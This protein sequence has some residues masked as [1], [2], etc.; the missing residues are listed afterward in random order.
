M[1]ANPFLAV[2]FPQ[3]TTSFGAD[4]VTVRATTTVASPDQ[5]L[6]LYILFS[7]GGGLIAN[8]ELATQMANWGFAV[9]KFVPNEAG[10]RY[11]RSMSIDPPREL[12][13]ITCDG[14]A[15]KDAGGNP[16]CRA[17]EG[18]KRIGESEAQSLGLLTKADYDAAFKFVSPKAVAGYRYFVGTRQPTPDEE[19]AALFVA[20]RWDAIAE[21]VSKMQ[22]T[23]AL[24][25]R[26]FSPK[27]T[28]KIGDLLVWLAETAQPVMVFKQEHPESFPGQ[29][30]QI[31]MGVLP[32]LPAITAGMIYAGIALIGLC[33]VGGVAVYLAQKT[34]EANR[35]Y[36]EAN[37]AYQEIE[38]ELADCIRDPNNS[39]MQR[40]FCKTALNEILGHKPQ[41]PKTQM[42][43][44][45]DLLKVALPL[46]GIGAAAIYVGPAILSASRTAASGI[47]T[48]RQRRITAQD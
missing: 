8:E 14:F 9:M 42:E 31:S 23:M 33:V 21:M 38:E 41:P 43:Q 32:A 12:G 25:G 40:Q 15:T 36:A 16:S 19:G 2:L 45:T 1:T 34:D 39:L 6:R 47:D 20:H 13:A 29:G 4:P 7:K 35:K 5:P 3:R 48:F 26:T 11:L 46:V 24:S 22:Q 18:L 37:E 10:A 27:I 17:E 30:T 44:I 28:Q